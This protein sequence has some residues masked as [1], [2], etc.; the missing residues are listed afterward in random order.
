MGSIYAKKSITLKEEKR[1]QRNLEL[2]LV[3]LLLVVVLV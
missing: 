2:Y 1:V 3:D